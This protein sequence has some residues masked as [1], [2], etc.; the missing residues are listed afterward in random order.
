MLL[1]QTRTPVPPELIWLNNNLMAALRTIQEQNDFITLMM[2]SFIE[3]MGEETVNKVNRS[4][5]R[6]VY[7]NL[8][9][10]KKFNDERELQPNEPLD[11]KIKQL[12]QIQKQIDTMRNGMIDK[13][14]IGLVK[15]AEEHLKGGEQPGWMK[16]I[17]KIK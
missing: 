11:G 7:M 5:N 13:F 17:I 9:E 6:K 14:G 12:E 10:S 15:E 2:D 3:S 4:I 16:G 8:L 1:N